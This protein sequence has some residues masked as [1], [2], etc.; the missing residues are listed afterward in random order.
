[1]TVTAQ[2]HNDAFLAPVAVA[3]QTEV[4]PL[5]ILGAVFGALLSGDTPQSQRTS[6]Q[7]VIRGGLAS[8]QNLIAGSTLVPGTNLSGFSVT[9]ALGMSVNQLAMAANYPNNQIS[10]TTTAALG[11]VGVPV[12]PSP[13][14]NN[15]LHA[16][17]VVPVPL[18]PT[19]AAQ[20]SGLFTRIPNPA[21]C[22]GGG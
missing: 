7:Y 14:T 21:K 11:G 12:V 4:G 6:P 10:Y 20:I 15:P 1:M 5:V 22:G 17:A 16:T 8:P 3:T 13:S 18:D 9:S 2:C 19:R